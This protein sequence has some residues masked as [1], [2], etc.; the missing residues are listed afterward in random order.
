MSIIQSRIGHAAVWAAGVVLLLTSPVRATDHSASVLD[1]EPCVT[2]G[3]SAGV[4]IDA[5][6][7]RQR[8]VAI[9]TLRDGRQLE[10][11]F[12]YDWTYAH[13]TRDN[14]LFGANRFRTDL[15]LRIQRPPR[16]LDPRTVSPVI[17]YVLEH[18]DAG[19]HF[20]GRA[21]PPLSG[22]AE[23]ALPERLE[24]GQIRERI[25]HATDDNLAVH[26][27]LVH[28]R[29]GSFTVCALALNIGTTAVER[30]RL[31]WDFKLRTGTVTTSRDWRVS[32]APSASPATLGG[33]FDAF[34]AMASHG[35]ESCAPLSDDPRLKNKLNDIEGISLTVIGVERAP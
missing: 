10:G 4:E 9:A 33:W 21:C 23:M 14:R 31:R 12:P 34:G 28:A 25:A 7:H 19:G 18:T 3:F 15:P 26:V 2:V 20:H 32:L 1:R 6:G 35:P 5:S 24:K 22:A 29:T 8:V 17:A 16:Q 30:V 11:V 27:A 13:P